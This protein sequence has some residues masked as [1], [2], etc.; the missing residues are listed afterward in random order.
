MRIPSPAL[1]RDVDMLDLEIL[2]RINDE[3]VEDLYQFSKDDS[4]GIEIFARTTSGSVVM[5][6]KHVAGRYVCKEAMLGGEARLGRE[7]LLLDLLNNWEAPNVIE[8]RSHDKERRTLYTEYAGRVNLRDYKAS[9]ELQVWDIIVQILDTVVFLHKGRYPD[10]N[11]DLV[12]EWRPI[13]H[14]RLDRSFIIDPLCT[15]VTLLGFG[16]GRFLKDSE[17]ELP[18]QNRRS[19]KKLLDRELFGI[20]IT[21]LELSVQEGLRKFDISDQVRDARMRAAKGEAFDQGFSM[22][23]QYW[24]H[25]MTDTERTLDIELVRNGMRQ[26]YEKVLEMMEERNMPSDLAFRELWERTGPKH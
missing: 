12:G 5:L 2:K 3:R 23:S 19:A 15:K 25:R 4:N 11:K 13:L 7:A 20:G 16:S 8:M 22:L 10:Y 18:P 26:D 9:G 21:L 6:C 24:F 1:L 17:M 14:G